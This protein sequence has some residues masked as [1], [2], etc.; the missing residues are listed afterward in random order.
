ML[1]F[2]SATLSFADQGGW[3]TFTN[4]GH[5]RDFVIRSD[6]IW[7]ASNGGVLVYDIREH[8]FTKLTN[9]EGLA[10][11][12]VSTIAIDNYGTLW[13]GLAD[14]RINRLDSYTQSWDLIDDFE[15]FAVNALAACGDTMFVGLNIGVSAYIISR[16]EVKETYKNLGSFPVEIPVYSILIH[17]RDIW[18]ATEYGVAKSNLDFVNLLAPQSWSNYTAEHDNLPSNR[19]TDLAELDSVIYVGTD[20]GVAKYDGQNWA[21]VNS[22]LSSLQIQDLHVWNRSLYAA[23]LDGIFQL[24]VNN[25]SWTR[26]GSPLTNI[27]S[28]SFDED[29]SLWVG[30]DG[31]ALARLSA[32]ATHWD[33]FRPDGP[34]GNFFSDLAFDKNGVLW[35][36]SASL[37]GK[38]FYGFAG[39]SWVNYSMKTG[40]PTNDV[41][42]VAV[43]N[44]NSKWFGTWGSGAILLK[45]D[46]DLTFF[47]S[48][49][50]HLVGIPEN[51]KYVVVNDIAV[52]Q[53][54]NVWMLNYRALNGNALA[55]VTP[56][57][58]WAYFSTADGLKSTLVTALAIDH[59]GRKWVGT[60]SG[61]ISILDDGGTPFDKS[62]DNVRSLTTVEGLVDNAI[63]A[64]AVDS[65]GIVWI[66]TPKGINFVVDD[67]VG[68]RWGLIS[69]DVKCISVDPRNN[70]WFG[71]TGGVSILD[72]D[73]YRWTHYTT[74]NSPL[75]NN[76]VT[77]IA[78]NP[79]TGEAFIGTPQGL[80]RLETPFAEVKQ[81]LTQVK[82]YPNPFLLADNHQRL[83]IDNLTNN[84]DIRIYSANGVLIKHIPSSYIL[85]PQA[86]W[87]GTNDRGKPVASGIYVIVVH[88]EQG[89][90]KVGK[91]AVVRK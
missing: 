16:Q 34:G 75:V 72:R 36:A 44:D 11:N 84:S 29:G 70:K 39:T 65:E 42:T 40:L 48:A 77:S 76:T 91:V 6:E 85:G 66:G 19:I 33:E 4:M 55:A 31:E 86:F 27:T 8:S 23:T 38:G 32:D 30:R 28:I 52:D 41:L 49:D 64:L 22:G 17:R 1:I 79:K 80:S 51:S 69:E 43:A 47:G 68:S 62:D 50:G 37:R 15:G 89:E 81:N 25:D 10:S 26:I 59:D 13:F 2:L 61:G 45:E 83:T 53:L 21:P 88:N 18:V 3:K 90:T 7:C 60:R 78:I 82:I 63:S 57:S 71:T 54:G 73:G 87:N 12:N 35:C 5:I 56:D 9:T 14:G 58:Q 46:G 67:K 20:E 24:N 74:D